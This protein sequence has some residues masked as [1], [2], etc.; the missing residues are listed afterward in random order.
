MLLMFYAEMC[1][2]VPLEVRGL[3]RTVTCLLVSIYRF[4]MLT[5]VLKPAARLE[6]PA[7]RICN[8]TVTEE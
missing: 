1:T 8:P 3:F 2:S 6:F 7:V 4:H 5:S